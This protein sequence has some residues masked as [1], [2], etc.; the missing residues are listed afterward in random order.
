[1]FQAE[2]EHLS[3]DTPQGG[4]TA[5]LPWDTEI[6]G[7]AAA[8]WKVGSVRA[9]FGDRMKIATRLRSYAADHGVALIGCSVPSSEGRWRT[10]LPHLGFAYVD[11]T[12]TYTLTKLQSTTFPRKHVP[13]RLATIEDQ[14]A[15]E[16]ICEI[17][18]RA[19]R[20]HADA[21]F[22]LALANLRYR[23]WLAN[24]FASLGEN[25]RIYVAGD[26]G[27]AI[28][29][30]HVRVNESGAYITIG[31]ADP[32]VQSSVLPFAVFIGTLE[33]LRDSG[34]RRAQ[35]KLS[36]GNTPM[37]NLAAYAGSRFSDPEHVYHWHAPDSPHLVKLDALFG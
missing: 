27:A 1:M 3:E 31:G 30:T 18:F 23:R 13:V 28:G 34:V 35:S 37:L 14:A 11:T 4:T 20:Y 21:R 9:V 12:L 8:D 25:N 16:R 33:A 36:A 29:F 10:L 26:V 22:P 5:V 7:F 24:E 19:G 32:A 15:V 2:Y 6:F 17:G